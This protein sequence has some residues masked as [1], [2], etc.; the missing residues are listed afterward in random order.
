[1]EVRKLKLNNNQIK[2]KR[3]NWR[4][5]SENVRFEHVPPEKGRKH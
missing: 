1:M 5:N 4:N 2:K 3:N